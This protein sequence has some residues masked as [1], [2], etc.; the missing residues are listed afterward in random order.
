M[1]FLQARALVFLPWTCSGCIL[2]NAKELAN[3]KQLWNLVI[4]VTKLSD[5]CARCSHVFSQET[6]VMASQKVCF[7][8]RLKQA[9]PF[10]FVGSWKN[11][12]TD[13]SFHGFSS[14]ACSVSLNISLLFPYANN[15]AK[16]SWNTTSWGTDELKTVF[17]CLSETVVCNGDLKRLE[18]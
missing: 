14:S 1:Q 9:K 15:R 5:S 10:S 6:S 2:Q 11:D 8:L 4:W 12:I 3:P 7:S 18:A 13:D 17:L 16:Y